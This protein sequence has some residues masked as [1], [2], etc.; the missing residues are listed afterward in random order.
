MLAAML[1]FDWSV[2]N[3]TLLVAIMAYLWRQAQLVTAIRQALL[4]FEGQA[5]ALDE[6]KLLRARMHDLA[7]VVTTLTATIQERDRLP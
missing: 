2:V 7:N 6:I 5:G 3:T 1:A 4:G